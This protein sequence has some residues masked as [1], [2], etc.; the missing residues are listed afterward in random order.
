MIPL[1]ESHIGALKHASL[2]PIQAEENAYIIDDSHEVVGPDSKALCRRQCQ[3][4]TMSE[5]FKQQ[6]KF[7]VS[8]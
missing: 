2:K 5:S 3:D 7:L 4:I 8:F 1:K 6:D